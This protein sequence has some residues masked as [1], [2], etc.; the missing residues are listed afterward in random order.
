MRDV[1]VR[2]LCVFC[3]GA[4]LTFAAPFRISAQEPAAGRPDLSGE[5][6]LNGDLSTNPGQVEEGRRSGDGERGRGGRGGGGRG[7][8]PGGFG[9]GGGDGRVGVP[10]GFGGGRSSGDPERMRELMQD[11][12]R[13]LSDPPT[14]MVLTYTDPKLAI[15]AADGRTRT[16]YTD[17]RKQKTNNGNADVQTRWDNNRVV[18]ETK[19]GSIKVIETYALA[20]DGQQLIVTARMDAPDGGRGGDRPKL[21]LRRVYDRVQREDPPSKN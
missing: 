19:F 21:A 10:G 3:L 9:G 17:K 6:T 20:A 15:A 16:L 12:Q 18:A 5:W 2:P 14:S 11:A 13:L 8:F 1:A 4:V 7:G